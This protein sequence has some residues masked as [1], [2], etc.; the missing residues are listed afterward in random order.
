MQTAADRAADTVKDFAEGLLLS[1]GRLAVHA[2]LLR[3]YTART[4]RE[5]RQRITSSDLFAAEPTVPWRAD[6][7]AQ[8]AIRACEEIIDARSLAENVEAP[9]RL[10]QTSGTPKA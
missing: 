4:I 10:S 2:D 3:D 7:I 6:P 1:Q 5:V 9:G 8:N